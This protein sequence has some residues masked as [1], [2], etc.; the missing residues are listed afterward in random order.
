MGFHGY[1]CDDSLTNITETAWLKFIKQYS[2]SS[3]QSFVFKK[4]VKIRVPLILA[5]ILWKL[6]NFLTKLG[7][8]YTY[9][10]P[11]RP[12]KPYLDVYGTQTQNEP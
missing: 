10:Y 4:R 1:K 8:N 12:R 11:N 5:V 9:Y 6:N 3:L 7:V 2:D